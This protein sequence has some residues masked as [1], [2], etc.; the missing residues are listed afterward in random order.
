MGV[1][2]RVVLPV[3][4]LGVWAVIAVALCVIAFGR[5]TGAGTQGETAGSLTPTGGIVES[6]VPAT[7]GSVA[8]TVE[9]VGTVAADPATTVKATTAGKVGRVRVEVGEAVDAETALVDVVVT[10]EPVV[11]PVVTAP[12]GTTTQ[13]PPKERTKT[14]AV[15]AG[16]AGTVASLAV[17]KDQDVAVGTDVATISPGTLSVT[18]P[19][20]QA[21]QFR[22]LTPPASATA[23]AKGGPAPF[24]CTGVSTGAAG[25]SDPA[26][27]APASPGIDP[28]TGA[29]LAAP[30][31][32]V[33]CAVP[34]GTTVFAGMSVDLTLDVGSAD[35]V[36]T[37]PVTAVQGTVAEGLVWVVGPDGAPVERPVRLGLTDGAVVAIT[38]GL[39]EGEE[40]LEFT[41]VPSDDEVAPP[42]D[43]AVFL[44]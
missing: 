26:A 42:E 27:A 23:Q 12:D 16:R 2:R 29:P 6:T 15:L 44:G 9:L 34:P 28:Y 41:P 36:V 43:G 3:L 13:A 40:V 33:R 1:F 7:L 5:G 10:L 24:S 22:L 8:S 4:R 30:T 18:A 19:L 20:T 38:E 31:A 11:A 17:L 14:V 25:A 35:G 21:Q 39:A 32:Q 37:V